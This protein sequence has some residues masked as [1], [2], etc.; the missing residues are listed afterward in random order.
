MN[1]F[2]TTQLGLEAAI[3]ASGAR[4]QAIAQNLANANTPG[5]RRVDVSFE[6]VL[7]ALMQS[8]SRSGLDSFTPGAEVD[9]SAPVRVDGNSVD[10]DVENSEQAKNGILYE[11][12]VA[13]AR[14]RQDIMRSAM[15]VG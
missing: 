8:G 3:R 15:G 9:G 7:G 5:Y 4:Q 11:S 14:T 2:D 10:V 13:V 6:N 12:L 1:L